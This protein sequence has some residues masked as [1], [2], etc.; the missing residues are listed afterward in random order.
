MNPESIQ[1][2]LA[3]F[4]ALFWFSCPHLYSSG[5]LSQLSSTRFPAAAAVLREKAQI[6]PV[7][8]TCA[9]QNDK[10]TELR[11]IGEHRGAFCSFLVETKTELTRGQILD[12]DS[13]I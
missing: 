13:S 6:N 1:S 11:L 10:Q 4:S 5:S 9:A 2:I 3:S 12:L 7:Y 8:T